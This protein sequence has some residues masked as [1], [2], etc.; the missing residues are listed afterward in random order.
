M[1]HKSSVH[2]L[3]AE[4]V[5]IH[6]T[7]YVLNYNAHDKQRIN[8]TYKLLEKV[9]KNPTVLK[10]GCVFN[11]INK[12]ATTGT[13]STG[14]FDELLDIT[15]NEQR[16]SEWLIVEL[17]S[18]MI[19]EKLGFEMKRWKLTSRKI[20][21]ITYLLAAAYSFN[22]PQALARISSINLLIW[23]ANS[24]SDMCQHVSP[25]NQPQSLAKYE[26]SSTDSDLPIGSSMFFAPVSVQQIINRSNL[27]TEDIRPIGHIVQHIFV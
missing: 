18:N 17:E 10:K 27:F 26:N 23:N 6:S 15:L 16:V 20:A 13:I 19:K 14:S 25:L 12:I 3:N 9:S 22:L 11:Y 2:L 24:K 8:D 1:C 21:F 4:F 5:T 7:I